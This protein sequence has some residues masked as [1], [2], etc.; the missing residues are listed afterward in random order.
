M[1]FRSRLTRS[2]LAF[3]PALGAGTAALFPALPVEIRELIAEGKSNQAIAQI[4]YVSAASVE[5]YI[6]SIFHKLGLERDD[7]GNRRV[8]AA[9]AHLENAE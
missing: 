1:D 9:L 4:L 6:T 5:K 7:S 8:L 2:P 3:D